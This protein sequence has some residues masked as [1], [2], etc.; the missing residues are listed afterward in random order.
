MV[1]VAWVV[2]PAV[3]NDSE[4]EL[5]AGLMTVS[6]PRVVVLSYWSLRVAVNRPEFWPAVAVPGPESASFVAAAGSTV[7][8]FELPVSLPLVLVAVTSPSPTA[9][10]VSVTEWLERAPATN[11][12][13]VVHPAEQ[14][15]VELMSTVPVNPVT[16]LSS[17]SWATT[18]TSNEEPAVCVPIAPP[19]VLVTA[20]WSRLPGPNVRLSLS[21]AVSAS[22]L[23]RVAVRTTPDSA[24]G[25]AT[26]R[27][28][29]ELVPASIVPVN[30]P[31]SDPV[32]A[33]SD[34][35]TSVSAPTG[36]VLPAP[37]C[38]STVTEK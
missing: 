6:E 33:V 38:A 34:S 28:V 10:S 4:V 2:P 3:L 5:E 1:K 11:A 26:P 14:V 17:A 21:P 32:P 36:A 20:K 25:Y 23:V 13:L 31:P 37:S 12:A 35:A 30:V 16:V 7:K 15:L 24:R 19:D 29:T 27:I 8:S 9:T 18:L 22:P